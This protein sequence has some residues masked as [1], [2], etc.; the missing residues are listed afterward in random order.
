MRDT[1]S[2]NRVYSVLL[3][4]LFSAVVAQ[5]TSG[6][7]MNAPMEPKESKLETAT[8]AG[9]CFWCIEA[10]FEQTP[11]VK[12]V[13]SGYI[14]GIEPN[15]SYDQ[16]CSGRT[17]HAEA[18]QITFDPSIISFNQLLD[19]FWG[20]HDPTQLNRQ[21][22]DIGTQYRSAVFYHSD[23]QKK[24]TEESIAA[25]NASGHYKD[26]VVT[27]LEPAGVFYAAEAYHQEYYRN[28]RA[29]PYCQYVI[30][31]KLKKLGLN[32]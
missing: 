19:V 10:V 4:A 25:L 11:G 32:P 7:D 3:A 6:E 26:K 27:T 22:N 29:Q 17:G 15:P 23:E 13:V 18:C 20:A 1:L 28:N 5:T 8:L 12:N 31:P 21:G 2:M 24:T 16:V 9:G 14:G 30:K